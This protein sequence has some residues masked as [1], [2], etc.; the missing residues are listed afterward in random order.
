M[1]CPPNL[2][3]R[4]CYYGHSF[5][6]IYFTG[7]CPCDCHDGWCLMQL[8]CENRATNTATVLLDEHLVGVPACDEHTGR[9]KAIGYV[10]VVEVRPL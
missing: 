3:E 4:N 8:A 9:C 10:D 2:C 1:R 6:G 7:L 5:L